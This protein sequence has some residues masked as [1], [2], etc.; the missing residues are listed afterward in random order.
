MS[1]K[2]E[3]DVQWDADVIE[4]WQAS[5]QSYKTCHDAEKPNDKDPETIASNLIDS[6]SKKKVQPQT[7]MSTSKRDESSLHVPK[8]KE[9][10][11]QHSIA[12]KLPP[13][14]VSHIEE[15]VDGAEMTNIR[16]DLGD[17]FDSG[18]KLPKKRKLPVELPDTNLPPRRRNV[19]IDIEEEEEE[20]NEEEQYENQEQVEQEAHSYENTSKKARHQDNQQE[21]YYQDHHYDAAAPPPPPAPPMPLSMP[22]QDNEAFSNLIMSWYYAGYYTGLYQARQ[23]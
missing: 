17:V 7:S 15:K 6:L 14:R 5:L 19:Q 12:M 1:N 8:L 10:K 11:D 13:K 23:R 21:Y 22:A 16:E 3:L 2:D 20:Q 4:F 9:P 18:L